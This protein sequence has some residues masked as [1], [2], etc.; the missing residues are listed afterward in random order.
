MNSQH[1]YQTAMY[2]LGGLYLQGQG[3][4]Q[5]N[6][7]AAEL[8]KQS[9]AR[10]N[11]VSQRDQAQFHLQIIKQASLVFAHN[12]PLPIRNAQFTK[13]TNS[14]LQSQLAVSILGALYEA[15]QGVPQSYGRA[16]ELYK[17]GAAQGEPVSQRDQARIHVQIFKR[18]S[19]GLT[20]M[21][22]P[23]RLN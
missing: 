13:S 11:A 21:S 2:N 20:H 23:H 3:V 17:Q 12:P 19:V 6:E 7:R 4:P 1:Q 18:M 10:G 9:A 14:Q 8:Y 5:S 16:A 15:G 22:P